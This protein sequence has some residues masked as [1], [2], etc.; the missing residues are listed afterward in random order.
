MKAYSLYSS[1]VIDKK[2]ILCT[3]SNTGIYCSSDK[4][5]SSLPNIIYFWKFHHQH[6]CTLQLVWRHGMLLTWVHLTFLYSE[7]ALSQKP[8]GIGHMYVHTF[9]L[10]M[11]DI[12]TSQSIDLSSWDTLYTDFKT[13]TWHGVEGWISFLP[14][15]IK[16][17]DRIHTNIHYFKNKVAINIVSKPK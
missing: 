16:P 12:M 1:K 13:S 2:Q 14:L 9:L 4:S 7:I 10:R 17:A 11:T 6:Q 15:L 8:L 5:W 3:V